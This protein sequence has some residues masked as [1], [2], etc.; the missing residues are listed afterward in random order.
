MVH[1]PN[2]WAIWVQ[3][4]KPWRDVRSWREACTWTT[5]PICFNLPQNIIS[6]LVLKVMSRQLGKFLK[7]Y[8]TTSRCLKITEKVSFNITSEASYFYILS[9]QK[10]IKNAKNGEFLKTWILRPNSVTRQVSF[11]RTKIG[12]KCQNSQIQMRHFW[13][14]LKQCANW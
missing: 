9:G 14:F 5:D 4:Y 1:A 2:A 3:I 6:S 10:L 8:Y 7:F 12:G 13:V 11:N